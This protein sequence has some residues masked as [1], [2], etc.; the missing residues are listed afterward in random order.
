MSPSPTHPVAGPRSRG[1]GRGFRSAVAGLVA[2]GALPL[3]AQ[4]EEWVDYGDPY[5]EQGYYADPGALTT[6]IWLDRGDDPV[7]ER[8]ERARIY[9][10]ASHDA[11]IAL[12]HIDTNGTVRLMYPRS[13][14]ENHYVRGG[15]DFRLVFPE[16]SYWR[17]TDDP[18]VGYFFAV[19]SPEPFDFRDFRYSPYAGGWDLSSV[20]RRVFS[21]PYV[22]MDEFVARLIPDWDVVPYALDFVSYHVEQRYDYP[23]FLCYDC[24]GFRPYQ[25]WNPYLA[26]C[27]SFRVVVYSDPYYYPATRYRGTRVV[28]VRPS[29]PGLPRFE[30]KER[31]RGEAAAPLVVERSAVPRSGSVAPSGDRRGAP[32]PSSV[33]APG[34]A[35]RTGAP[36][37]SPA[38]TR[39]R[40]SQVLPGR[41]VGATPPTRSGT[42][43]P[44][45]RPTLERRTPTTSTPPTA[46][47][48]GGGGTTPPVTRPPTT[49]SGGGG[50]T[51][52]PV[53]RPP[54]TRSG[55]GGGTTPPVTTRR[56]GG[57]GSS[58]PATT[59]PPTRSSGGG[60]TTPPV[61]TR[62]G[63]G[64]GDPPPATTRPP[65]R[66]SGGGAVRSTPT[67]STP[68]RATP[69]RSSGGGGAARSAPT[70]STPARAT[71][72]RSSGGGGATRAT[73]T[74]T[75][76]TRSSGGGAATRTTPTR[77]GGGGG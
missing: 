72:T 71:P 61:T 16:S 41:G 51:T 29:Q 52:P 17:V 3:A 77:R 6:R 39:T 11:F 43:V 49:R 27:T 40:P 45:T 62:R 48:G 65:T 59:R 55:G 8:G 1:R 19:A 60:G 68:A 35:P 63:G 66:S 14:E 30:F 33:P 76:P 10:R 28:Y 53:A 9:Y 23:R 31:A 38:P 54:T 24:H 26:S 64:G 25:S 4:N 13:P 73:P 50:G 7:L 46:R 47:S 12:F 67:R 69:T 2:L 22:A 21:D 5:A 42:P 20:G 70:R 57:G 18:G 15:R 32:V 44:S 75:T 37:A 56:G 74:R 58:P 36:G 34:V